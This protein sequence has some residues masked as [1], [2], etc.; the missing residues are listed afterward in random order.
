MWL[1]VLGANHRARKFYE[2]LGFVWIKDA[3]LQ[4]ASQQSIPNIPA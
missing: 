3:K 1:E 4:T 2:N